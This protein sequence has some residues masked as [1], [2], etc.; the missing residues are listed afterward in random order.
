MT[1][2]LALAAMG[3]PKWNTAPITVYSP[4]YHARSTKSGRKYDHY[5]GFTLAVPRS[6]WKRLGNRHIVVRFKGG[7][8]RIALVNDV[9]A[10][11]IKSNFDLSGHLWNQITYFA[12]P[13]RYA[14]GFEWRET[15]KAERAKVKR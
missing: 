12:K 14:R 7:P 3:T 8:E 1:A 5:R 6:Y 15:T 10:K 13:T 2:I 4:V 9:T 11:H